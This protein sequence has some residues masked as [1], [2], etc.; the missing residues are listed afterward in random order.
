MLSAD[1]R[2]RVAAGEVQGHP[3]TGQHPGTPRWTRL[4]PLLPHL[5]K[6]ITVKNIE[7]INVTTNLG[8]C[9][10]TSSTVNNSAS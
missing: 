4:G 5:W 3:G 2:L 9:L 7:W 10:L 1:H 6:S 8:F